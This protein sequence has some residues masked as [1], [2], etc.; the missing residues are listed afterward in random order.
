M[1]TPI[2]DRAVLLVEFVKYLIH[3]DDTYAATSPLPKDLRDALVAD[4][5]ALEAA[6]MRVL[7]A[8]AAF[9]EA[10]QSRSELGKRVRATVRKARSV[11]YG[12]HGRTD[13]ALVEYG[14]STP[15]EKRGPKEKAPKSTPK[16]DVA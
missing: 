14:L 13:K 7:A 9:S 1:A 2:P 16:S 11:V 3:G 12:L 5:D 6:N 15:V 4:R 10:V 8:R